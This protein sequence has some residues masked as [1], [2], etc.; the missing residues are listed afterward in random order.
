[1]SLNYCRCLFVHYSLLMNYCLIM[2]SIYCLTENRSIAAWVLLDSLFD[3]YQLHGYS[4]KSNLFHI[5][6]SFS[7]PM[8]HLQ[9][10]KWCTRM[11]KAKNPITVNKIFLC[12]I[13]VRKRLNKCCEE[14]KALKTRWMQT[15]IW[16]LKKFILH[17]T[18]EWT[19]RVSNKWF[20]F[21]FFYFH[22][23]YYVS[24]SFFK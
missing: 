4:L 16:R 13:N 21:I 19:S 15:V 1:M 18:E 8:I 14:N 2:V 5:H 22:C 20:T 12:E 17:S 23:I 9:L 3:S 24:S 11:D 7:T 10:L 6:F